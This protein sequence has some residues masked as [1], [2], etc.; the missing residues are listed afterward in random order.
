VNVIIKLSVITGQP[1]AQQFPVSTARSAV[2]VAVSKE[3]I[4]F[5]CFKET[6]FK[7]KKYFSVYFF[8]F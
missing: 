2:Y 7:E 6:F 1:P 4:S 5:V 8:C 3:A